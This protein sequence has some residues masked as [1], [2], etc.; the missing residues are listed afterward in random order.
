[1]KHS[2]SNDASRTS[3]LSL[4]IWLRMTEPT[5]TLNK[6]TS[7]GI[8]FHIATMQCSCT[9]ES[10]SKT[11]ASN[12]FK[13][14]TLHD[15]GMVFDKRRKANAPLRRDVIILLCSNSSNMFMQ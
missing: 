13:H 15:S 2:V 12:V 6:F 8:N 1:M 11:T 3:S 7:F 14:D 10:G 4:H 5:E 9:T